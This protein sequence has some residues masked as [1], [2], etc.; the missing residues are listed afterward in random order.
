MKND[1]WYELEFNEELPDGD[2]P[3]EAVLTM[4]ILVADGNVAY[5]TRITKNLSVVEGIG[6]A[7]LAQ[8]WLESG[9]EEETP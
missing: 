9:L 6:M 5:V 7:R 3:L 8:L 4:K 1:A 2:T